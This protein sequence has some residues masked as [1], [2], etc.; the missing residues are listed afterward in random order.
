ME[1]NNEKHAVMKVTKEEDMRKVLFSA[2]ESPTESSR[3]KQQEAHIVAEAISMLH[4]MDLRWLPSTREDFPAASLIL[5]IHSWS[6]QDFSGLSILTKK[7]SFVGSFVSIPEIQ[8]RN[9]VLKHCG[10]LD[11]EYPVLFTQNYKDAMITHGLFSY[12]VEVNGTRYSMHWIS[13]AHQNSWRVL[14]DATALVMGE[15]QLHLALYRPDFV[16]CTCSFFKAY[17]PLGK[18]KILRHVGLFCSSK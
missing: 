14:L 18:N 3:P 8:A 6:H 4:G 1:K 15:D 17:L 2:T 16:L 12:L 5:R 9:K 11:E 7:S 13:E 10:L